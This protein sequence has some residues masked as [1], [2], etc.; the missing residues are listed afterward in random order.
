VKNLSIILNGVLIIAVAVLYYLHFKDCRT[1]EAEGA[2][3]EV[4]DPSKIQLPPDLQNKSILYINADSLNKKYVFV[5]QLQKETEAKQKRLESTYESRARA[6]QD[7][8]TSYQE[9]IQAGTVTVDQAKVIEEGLQRKKQEI[10]MMEGQLQ[11]LMEEAQK[12]NLQVQKEVFAFLKEF[13]KTKNINYVFTYSENT[14][15]LVFA[16]DSLDI[17]DEVLNGLNAKYNSNKK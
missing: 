6:F 10:D 12:K 4:I 7:E 11:S 14:P 8:Y 15:G 9:K 3:T 1:P 13:S 2:V 16:N 17:T 5:Q